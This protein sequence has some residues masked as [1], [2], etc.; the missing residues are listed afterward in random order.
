MDQFEQAITAG[1]YEFKMKADLKKTL[2]LKNL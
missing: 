1:R 2:I